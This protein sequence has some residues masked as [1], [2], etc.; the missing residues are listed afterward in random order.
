MGVHNDE[1]VHSAVGLTDH[2]SFGATLVVF[3][4]VIVLAALWFSLHERGLPPC[5]SSSLGP[6]CGLGMQSGCV[7]VAG[8]SQSTWQSLLGM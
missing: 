2:G 1:I 5:S 4:I 7:R 6:R 8:I 3:E